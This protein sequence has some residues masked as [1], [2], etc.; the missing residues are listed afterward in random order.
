MAGLK[1]AGELAME[2]DIA[3]TQLEAMEVVNDRMIKENIEMQQEVFLFFSSLRHDFHVLD[4]FFII[5]GV[6]KCI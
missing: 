1:S 4:V 2:L 3:E 6:I 5:F